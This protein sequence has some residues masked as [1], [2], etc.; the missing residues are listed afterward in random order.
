MNS[1]SKATTHDEGAI[2]EEEISMSMVVVD[3]RGAVE[4]TVGDAVLVVAIREA[5][6]TFIVEESRIVII[7]RES[8]VR[9]E[10]AGEIET[11]SAMG[12][13]MNLICSG[14]GN[15]EGADSILSVTN[16]SATDEIWCWI[17]L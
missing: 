5:S 17:T 10:E 9:A 11:D 1:S 15:V 4:A 8:G 12:S 16:N 6:S 7:A 2:V 13:G 3:S 14:T